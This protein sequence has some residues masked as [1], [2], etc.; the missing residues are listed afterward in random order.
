MEELRSDVGCASLI[1]IR[2]E[3]RH[4]LVTAI[5]GP[6]RST[7]SQTL[8]ERQSLCGCTASNVTCLACNEMAL[9]P[10]KAIETSYVKGYPSLA[11]FIASDLDHSSVLYKRFDKLSARNI[12]YLQSELAELER[13]QVEFDEQDFLD[14]SLST[15]KTARDWRAFSDV[16]AVTGSRAEERMKLSMEI[17]SKIKEHS[18]IK[19]RLFR[20]VGPALTCELRRSHHTR[21]RHPLP[22]PT[23]QASIPRLSKPLHECRPQWR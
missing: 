1:C 14:D 9:D 2:Q 8:T 12:L 20:R 7:P 3:R 6:S 5:L 11:A 15:K 13:R 23:L 4:H 19:L 16:A 18:K 10:E 17:R 22:S 21:L